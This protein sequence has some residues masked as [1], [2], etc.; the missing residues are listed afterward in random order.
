MSWFL[1]N[2]NSNL[3]AAEKRKLHAPLELLDHPP[4]A[5]LPYQHGYLVSTLRICFDAVLVEAS[6]LPSGKEMELCQGLE[7]HPSNTI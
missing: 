5:Y 1:K 6:V 2:A 7:L 3:D 4:I